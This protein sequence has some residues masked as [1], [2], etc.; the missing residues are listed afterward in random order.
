MMLVAF[1]DAIYFIPLP[2]VPALLRVLDPKEQDLRQEAIDLALFHYGPSSP[3][4][5]VAR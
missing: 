2:Q 4:G 5:V 3:V 1:F